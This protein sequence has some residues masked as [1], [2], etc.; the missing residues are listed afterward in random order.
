MNFEDQLKEEF[1]KLESDYDGLT[2]FM[3]K[4][5]SNADSLIALG[6]EAWL[7]RRKSQH[8]TRMTDDQQDGALTEIEMEKELP[9][10]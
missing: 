10:E 1:K 9:N 4:I 3:K 2:D 6:K 7:K 8:Q 5:E